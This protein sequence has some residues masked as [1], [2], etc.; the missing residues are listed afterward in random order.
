[1]A[2]M[3]SFS[4]EARP[5]GDQASFPNAEGPGPYRSRRCRRWFSHRRHLSV[6][7]TYRW[8]ATRHQSQGGGLLHEPAPRRHPPSSSPVRPRSLGKPEFASC[9]GHASHPP[10]EALPDVLAAGT[11]ASRRRRTRSRTPEP[12]PIRK[13]DRL[14][15]RTQ[16]TSYVR[17]N[18]A[19]ESRFA[20][21][22]QPRWGLGSEIRL[23]RPLFCALRDG[24][25]MRALRRRGLQDE[26]SG[27]LLKSGMR[28]EGEDLL[29]VA[30]KRR[31]EC[32]R[33][34]EAGTELTLQRPPGNLGWALEVAVPVSQ[35]DIDVESHDRAEGSDGPEID[36]DRPLDHRR[37]EAGIELN[38]RA[39]G[40]QVLGI[41]PTPPQSSVLGHAKAHV[42]PESPV[43]R[44][45]G[46]ADSRR[47][48]AF[49]LIPEAVDGPPVPA[50][51][52]ESKSLHEAAEG[53]L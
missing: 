44:F 6:V 15:T 16:R 50:R 31:L 20:V 13:K 38:G 5:G 53:W 26:P 37:E 39:P 36:R 30:E 35:P 28:V 47:E 25:T 49:H 22:T 42:V 41:L 11:P 21:K 40:G 23:P 4:V 1:M 12:R 33:P 19:N 52:D 8:Q 24:A 17:G 51:G 46:A 32:W 48:E 27:S 43:C 2:P 45:V 14:A 3:A 9:P 18:C 7:L 10:A 34:G 29:G